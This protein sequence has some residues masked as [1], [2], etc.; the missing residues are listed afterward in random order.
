MELTY[1][2]EGIGWL[3]VVGGFFFVFEPGG[4]GI[5]VSGAFILGLAYA[6]VFNGF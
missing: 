6:G 1:I 5:G 2:I 4:L 3:C